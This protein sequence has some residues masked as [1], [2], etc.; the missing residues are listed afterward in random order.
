V[1]PG[2]TTETIWGSE[3]VELDSLPQVLNPSSGYVFNS[4]NTPFSSSASQNNPKETQYN[5]IMGFQ[6]TG[7]ENNRSLR[8]MELIKDYETLTYEDFKRI[9]YDHQYPS[10]LTMPKGKNLE[11]ILHLNANKYPEISDAIDMLNHWDRNT[12]LE[13]KSAPLAILTFTFINRVRRKDGPIYDGD[14]IDESHMVEAIRLAKNELNERFGTLALPLSD[15]QEHS[16]ADVH[17]PMRGGPDVLSAIYS[18]PQKKGKYKAIAGESYIEM[19]KFG[20]EGVKIE[21]I[22][23]FGASEKPDSKHFTDQMEYFSTQKLKKMSLKKE[24]VFQN[25]IRIY[26]PG[27]KL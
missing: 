11:D 8:F 24:E 14:R 7:V 26:S 10:Y 17:L 18:S 16:R 2:N 5:E 12:N 4:N 15:F 23:A 3:I 20:P 13:N 27:G 25:A 6:S 21:S 19:V 1:L 9:K 22:N